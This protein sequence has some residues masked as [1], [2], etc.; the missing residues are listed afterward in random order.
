[1]LQKIFIR[2][3]KAFDHNFNNIWSLEIDRTIF[4]RSQ[5]VL[6]RP[7][8]SAPAMVL[9]KF[10]SGKQRIAFCLHFSASKLASDL[11]TSEFLTQQKNCESVRD[12]QHS[13]EKAQ[14]DVFCP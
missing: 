14:C 13:I 5:R 9:E 12:K 3:K 1:M 2:Y 7:Q 8:S 4:E 10:G 6:F 11:R